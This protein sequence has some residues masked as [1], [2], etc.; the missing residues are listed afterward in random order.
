VPN[1]GSGGAIELSERAATPLFPKDHPFALSRLL[2]ALEKDRLR[3]AAVA[4]RG[5]QTV[6]RDFT[7]NQMMERTCEVFTR[8]A[9]QRRAPELQTISP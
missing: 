2:S 7:I 8:V 5:Q 9:N 3:V 6:L 4:L 1:T